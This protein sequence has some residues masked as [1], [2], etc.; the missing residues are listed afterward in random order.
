ML[1]SLIGMP[2]RLGRGQKESAY[3]TRQYVPTARINGGRELTLLLN[4]QKQSWLK[5]ISEKQITPFG[6]SQMSVTYLDGSVGPIPGWCKLD[7]TPNQRLGDSGSASDDDIRKDRM[8]LSLSGNAE[9]APHRTTS[10]K[11]VDI[12]DAA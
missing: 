2:R 5:S 9:L 4:F 6:N 12:N 11:L 7:S 3:L 1:R 8:M 10:I